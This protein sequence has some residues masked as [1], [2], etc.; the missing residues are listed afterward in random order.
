MAVGS[1]ADLCLFHVP[2]REAFRTLTGELVRAI[3]VLGRHIGPA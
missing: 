3:Y 2:L 1:D